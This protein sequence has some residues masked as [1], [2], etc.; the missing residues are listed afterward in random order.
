MELGSGHAIMAG[1]VIPHEGDLAKPSSLNTQR[2]AVI[3]NGKN[4]SLTWSEGGTPILESAEPQ[5]WYKV[6]VVMDFPA[7]TANIYLGW[8]L[9]VKDAPL[10]ERRFFSSERDHWY[11]LNNFALHTSS[12]SGTVGYFDGF[13]IAEGKIIPPQ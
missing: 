4:H 6:R 8:E 11:E 12:T 3:L 10:C 7:G 1:T 13:R 5:Q 2:N 9:K